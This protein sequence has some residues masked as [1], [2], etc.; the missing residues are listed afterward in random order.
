[1]K[2]LKAIMLAAA[3][4]VCAVAAAQDLKPVKDKS[5]KKFG[6]QAKDKSWVIQPSFDKAQKFVDGRAVVTVDGL[7][8]LIDQSGAWLLQPEFNNIGKFDKNGLSEVMVKEGKSKF[9]G[10]A[11]IHGRIILPPDCASISF[12]RNENLIMAKREAPDGTGSH[13]GIYDFEGEQV[14]APQFSSAPSF[15]RGIGVARSSYTGLVG[16][17]SSD[18]EV[19]LP[20]ENMAISESGGTREVLTTD[21]TI[22]NY[23]Q[24]MIKTGELRSPG[25]IIP[26]ELAGDDVRIASWHAGPI[27]VRLHQNNICAANLS[28]DASGRIA[29]CNDLGLNWGY[30]RFVRLEPEIEETPHPGAMENPL[31][32]EMYTLRALMYEADGSYVGVVSDW[33]WLEGEY[34]GGFVYNAEGQDMWLIQDGVNAPARRPGS[35]VKLRSWQPIDHS[36]VINGLLLGATDLNRLG[37]LSNRAKRIQDIM[38]AENVGVT[39]YLHRPESDWRTRKQIDAAMRSPL[40][41]HPFM[42][43]DVVNCKVSKRGDDM[44]ISLADGLVCRFE[45]RFDD[46]YF[47]MDGEEE[48]YWGPRGRRTVQL[49]LEEA[50]RGEP[51]MENDMQEGGRPLRCVIALYTED[52]RYLRTLGVAPGPDFIHEGVIVFEDLGIALI[53]RKPGQYIA[54]EMRF[55]VP[56]SSRLPRQ[57]SAIYMQA[58]LPPKN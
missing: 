27:G 12:T 32:G 3:L 18:G 15:S 54:P 9:Y 57:L 48:I 34:T 11:D 58:Q 19:L 37:N 2:T 29:L 43:G 35:S 7:E 50:D 51:A 45:D 14:F 1:M 20:F 47:R 49:I 41:R 24:R 46:P 26:Y 22:E 30:N 52:G 25:S 44:E 31:T 4:A 16:L 28:K 38:E 53:E 39:S 55:K 36:N 40:F 17:I 6:Y 10:V 13:W 21:F 42:M 8:G 33:G 56:A 5:T 23:D